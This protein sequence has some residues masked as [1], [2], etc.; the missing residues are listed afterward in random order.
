MA[1]DLNSDLGEATGEDAEARDAQL[2]GIIS[3]ANVA[4]GGHA[5]DEESMKRVCELAA[6]NAVAIGAHIS[7]VDK[8]GFG[9]RT[10]QVESETLQEQILVQLQS[11][12]LAAQAANSAVT[13]VKPHGTLYHESIDSAEL[14]ETVISAI[15]RYA[16]DTG[17]P[18]AILGLPDSQL[19]TKAHAV[20][21]TVV[22][23]AFADRT[24]D[25]AGRPIPR[26]QEGALITDPT[27]ALIQINRLLRDDEIVAIDGTRINFHA[28]S[29]CVHGD[30]PGA[31]TMARR[32]KAAIEAD[33]VRLSSFAPPPKP[34]VS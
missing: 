23:E 34:K 3:S 32:I 21:I 30:T 13:Y 19:L 1:I 16:S 9:H 5:G 26:D 2:L 15:L 14:A 22:N 8:E 28:R 20:G 24:Y 18:L 33:R 29:V 17:R 7:Y 4:C 31:V 6:L 25:P 27:Q 12:E 11:L 10:Y